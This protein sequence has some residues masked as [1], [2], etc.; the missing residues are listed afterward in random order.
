MTDAFSTLTVVSWNVNRRTDAWEV[1]PELGADEVLLQEAS[2]NGIPKDPPFRLASP[3]SSDWVIVGSGG[4]SATAS[5][6]AQ[7]FYLRW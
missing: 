6:R 3:P 4:A 2:R 1:L 7:E 5:L